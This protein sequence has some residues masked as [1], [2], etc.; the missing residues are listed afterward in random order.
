MYGRTHL[1]DDTYIHDLLVYD[2]LSLQAGHGAVVSLL[3]EH[4]A[5]SSFSMDGTGVTAFHFAC[6][7]GHVECAE[8]LVRAGRWA[9]Q[10]DEIHTQN[11]YSTNQINESRLDNLDRRRALTDLVCRVGSGADLM[12]KDCQG[13]TGLTIAAARGQH[14]G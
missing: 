2:V 12:Q 14:A 7:L 9:L 6:V 10:P 8:V 11:I 3:L 13:K 5:D 1:F 4:K